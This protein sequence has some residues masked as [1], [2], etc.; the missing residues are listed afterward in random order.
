MDVLDVVHTVNDAF[1]QGRPIP[2]AN[3]LC[4]V[5]TTDLDCNGV[6]DVFDVVHAVDVVFRNG[7][8]A[9]EYCEP[10]AP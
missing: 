4:P 8:P 9:T 6:N 3:A 7:D 2:D 5:V 10:C 1:R